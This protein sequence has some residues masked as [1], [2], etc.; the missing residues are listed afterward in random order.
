MI[1][2]TLPNEIVYNHIIPYTYQP[3][4]QNL[5]IDIKNYSYVLTFL[6]RFYN[7]YYIHDYHYKQILTFLK[8]DIRNFFFIVGG[9]PKRFSTIIWRIHIMDPQME[10][11]MIRQMLSYMDPTTRMKCLYNLLLKCN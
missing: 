5:L 6:F 10:Y 1:L 2:T 8:V 9:I 11:Y 4:S 3:Q 7:E